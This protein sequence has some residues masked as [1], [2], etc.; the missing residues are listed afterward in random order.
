MEI[1]CAASVLQGAEAFSGLGE[2]RVVPDREIDA[3]SLGCAEAL[4]IRS[5][6]R[7]TPELLAGTAV[8]F[9]ATAT[10]GT[11][12]LDVAGL[13]AAGVTVASAAGCNANAVAEYAVT[14]L[15][16]MAARTGMSLEG[17]TLGVVG[18]G[19]VGSRVARKAKSLGMGLVLNDPPLAELFGGGDLPA[20]LVEVD[21]VLD[22]AD[23][24]SLH[25]P[26]VD[27]GPHPTR[28]W[29]D[30][31]RLARWRGGVLLNASRGAVADSDALV[32]AIESGHVRAA[33]L[34]VWEGE[35]VWHPLLDRVDILTPH[36]AGYSLEGLLQGTLD[37]YRALCKFLGRE[38]AWQPTLLPS[39][40][41]TC[42]LAGLAP[43]D[44]LAAALSALCPVIVD[45]TRWRKAASEATDLRA[46]FDAFR[47]VST[48]R[49]EFAA[50]E[51]RLENAS[52]GLAPRFA[53]LGIR[54]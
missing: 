23:F 33:G 31:G 19:H 5:K 12:H 36:I 52:A 27:G 43:D 49:R 7:V 39:E 6:T 46:A 29:L 51:L 18:C 25:V 35:P 53:A 15:A 20:P 26:L 14:A 54:L 40:P 50:R 1:V 11:D 41:V 8:R 21:E 48:H 10:A 17:R 3:A 22:R 44:A 2:V 4:I 47:R 37:T 38:P 28:H 42:D 13:E 34:D 45:T 9:V 32:A 16:V 30:A 24:L